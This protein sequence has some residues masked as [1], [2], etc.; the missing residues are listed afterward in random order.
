MRQYNPVESPHQARCRDP[1]EAWEIAGDYIEEKLHWLPTD[2]RCKARKSPS[3]DKPLL[4]D[5]QIDVLESYH[6]HGSAQ[7]VAEEL[8]M[9]ANTVYVHLKNARDRLGAPDNHHA[10][11]KAKK[12]GLAG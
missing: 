5:T 8:Q 10:I 4:T 12:L 2:Q 3:E 6:K 1:E 11:N 7:A 9:S